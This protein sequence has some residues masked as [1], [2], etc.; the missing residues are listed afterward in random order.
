MDSKVAEPTKHES[1]PL[2]TGC[3]LEVRLLGSVAAVRDRKQIGISG[4]RQLATLALLALSPGKPVSAERL[5][6]GIWEDAARVQAR[7]G[8][9]VFVSSLRSALGPDA[10]KTCP[11]G[12]YALQIEPAQVDA[13][14]FA[15]L[16]S[17]VDDR[18]AE[19]VVATLRQALALWHGTAL[20][21]IPQTAAIAAAVDQLEDQRLRVLERCL[22][23]ELE[24][25]RHASILGEVT[26]LVAAAPLRERPRAQLMLSLY[27]CGRQSEALSCYRE[28]RRLLAELGVEPHPELRALEQAILNQDARLAPPRDAGKAPR[29]QNGVG[30]ENAARGALEEA[31]ALAESWAGSLRDRD[32]V[33]FQ[34]MDAQADLVGRAIQTAVQLADRENALRLLSALWFYWIVRGRHEWAYRWG[35]RAL[36]VSGEASGAIEARANVGLSEIARAC[37][38]FRRAADLKHLALRQH[39]DLGDQMGVA[40]LLADLAHLSLRLDDL[41]GAEIYATQALELRVLDGTNRGGVAHALL[42]LGEVNEQQ[43]N[44]V[45]AIAHYEEAIRVASELGLDSEAGYVQAR[46]LGRAVRKTGN[47][48]RAFGIYRRALQHSLPVGDTGNVA[49]AVHGLGWV[50][51]ERG[52]YVGAARHYASV[53]AADFQNS[54]ERAERQQ[55]DRDV[56]ELRNRV[57]P[58]DFRSAWEMGLRSPPL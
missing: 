35:E 45:A 42:A 26:E 37:G 48:Q 7:H 4:S 13:A 51:A 50:A 44:L 57:E 19:Q 29:T 32:E 3:P 34:V 16:S 20:T 39:R 41:T 12:A 27:R 21:G 31:V 23:A 52:D 6:D 38:E 28:G 56:T 8:L 47:H 2:P 40:A 18:P 53:S 36:E 9:H 54:L 17:D 55:F 11:G 10:I 43:Q 5:I 14:H 15:F 46:L 24:L 1:Y 30:E 22:A 25:G 58:S 49:A 33:A